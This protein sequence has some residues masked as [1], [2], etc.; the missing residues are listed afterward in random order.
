MEI[1][2]VKNKI[3]ILLAVT[4]MVAGAIFFYV[5]KDNKNNVKVLSNKKYDTNIAANTES[6]F[7]NDDALYSYLK[8]FGPKKTIRYLNELSAKFGSCHNVAHKAGRYAYEIYNEEAF[9]SCGSECH[10]GCYHGAAEAYFKDHGTADLAKNLNLLCNSELNEFFTHQCIHGIGH[11]LMAWADY[12]LPESLKSCDLLSQRQDSCWTGV[13]MENI[14]G[15]LAESDT[16]KNG[17]TDHFTK[18]LSDDPQYPC[19]IVE[20][21]YKGA[22]YFLQT[23]RMMQLFNGD[24]KRIADTCSKAEKPY[25]DSC[26]ASMGRDVGGS[27]AHNPKGSIAACSNAPEG[28][29][30]LLCLLG[31]VQDSL[32][33]PAGQDD[34][35]TFCKL[36]TNKKEKDGCYQ[37]IFAR[38]TEI[39]TS[40]KD[41]KIFC[42]KAESGYQS[43]CPKN[44]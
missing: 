24:F 18:Y 28:N 11:G 6:I 27:N 23:S 39:F 37:N 7:T 19:N 9:R 31:A 1:H 35:I 25:R 43:M 22:C 41:L 16:N 10:S 13:F 29:Y 42:S 17:D 30:R 14:V 38:A 20:D 44:I 12:D 32:W 4:L 5:S 3:A 15:G 40:N 26:F 21:K 8:K 2:I 36:L 33:D 34:A